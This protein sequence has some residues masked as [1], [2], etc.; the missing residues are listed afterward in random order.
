MR[1]YSLAAAV[2]TTLLAS[3]AF[4][5]VHA[6][7]A[8]KDWNDGPFQLRVRGVWMGTESSSEAFSIPTSKPGTLFPVEKDA[9]KTESG[10]Y[11]ELSGEYYFTPNWSTELALA[12]PTNF[13]VKFQGNKVGNQKLMPNTWTVKY[14]FM[15]EENFRPYLGAGASYT[16][17]GN[18]HLYLP[19]NAQ[20]LA[21]DLQT[22]SNHKIG[23]VGQAGFDYRLARSWFFNA[24]LRYISNLTTDVHTATGAKVTQ[25]KVTPLLVS[26]GIGYRFGGSP[27]VAAAPV[28]AAAAVAAVAPP[29][30]PPPP[31]PVA[32]VDPD[33]DGDGVPDSL[34]QCPNTP[35]GAKVDKV[36]CQCDV[37][38]EVH[39]A[40][41]SAQLSAEDKAMLD[42]VVPQLKKLHFIN[43]EIEGHTDSVGG[44][45]MNQRLSER[46]A[47][48]VADYL[49]A[50]GIS[51]GRVTTVGYGETKPVADNT[52]KEGRAHNRRVVIRRTDCNQ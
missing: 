25:L 44:S 20:Y 38:R 4:T 28:A 33:T 2:A 45:A 49:A 17:I 13:D 43:G 41:G 21:E 6:A 31:A 32:K 52:S 50:H 19:S 36:G 16:T 8:G 48:A 10:T 35:R 47:K 30:P 18:Q 14:G 37:T 1:K 11:A 26:I 39:F 40:T 22:D 23:F 34:D 51:G 42:D 15:P 29:P 46:R 12:W 24:D 27:I 3:V 5:S 7:D 9:L